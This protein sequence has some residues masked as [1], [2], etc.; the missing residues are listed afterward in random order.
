M[1]S[2]KIEVPKGYEID[3]K[4]STFEN[5]VFKPCKRVIDSVEAACEVLGEC[6][7]NVKELRKLE[8][9]GCDTTFQSLV[10]GVKAFN[11]GW[12]PNWSDSEEYKYFAY[13]SMD[14]KV[15]TFHFALYNDSFAAVPTRLY[16][17][18]RSKVEEFVNIKEF[19][20]LYIKY[21][22]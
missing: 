16:F 13:Y 5:I 18:S 1:K 15:P 22:S 14:K 21:L 20:D 9:A 2:I 17:S 7:E 3:E 12:E 11:E 19:N 4:K 10:V 6:D 8:C